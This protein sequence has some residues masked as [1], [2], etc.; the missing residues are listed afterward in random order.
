MPRGQSH[1]HSVFFRPPLMS[2]NLFWR[3]LDA[4]LQFSANNRPKSGF[5][6][7]SR[8]R[9]NKRARFYSLRAGRAISG[10]SRPVIAYRLWRSGS[11]SRGAEIHD[12]SRDKRP[13]ASTRIGTTDGGARWA[14][15]ARVIS[16][17]DLIS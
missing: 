17:P 5:F 13:V 14:R 4:T 11:P 1:R 10:N 12:I 7:T 15:I 8:Y 9:C 6:G 3:D 2:P 16:A